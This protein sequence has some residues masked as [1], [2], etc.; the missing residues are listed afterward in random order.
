MTKSI[1]VLHIAAGDDWGGAES[2]ITGL[3]KNF[4]QFDN[5][6]CQIVTMNDGLLSERLAEAD[7]DCVILDEK[8]YSIRELWLQIRDVI[9]EY[10]PDIIHTH[11]YKQNILG[12]L[13]AIGFKDIKSVRTQH[14][15]WEISTKFFSIAFLY[16]TLD[17]LFAR[18]LQHRTIAVSH[19]LKETLSRHVNRRKIVII[20]NG[21]DTTLYNVGNEVQLSNAGD[22]FVIA[23][24]GRLVPV[25]RIDLFLNS[26]FIVIQQAKQSVRCKVYGDGP[27]KESATILAER[28][29][30]TDKVDFCGFLPELATH[31]AACDLLL[32]TSDHEGLPMVLLESL[33]MKIPVVAPAI[34]GIPEILDKEFGALVNSQDPENY[35]EAILNCMHRAP[36]L[37]T[38][39]RRASKLIEHSYSAKRQAGKYKDFY[40]GL[41]SRS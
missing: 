18:F 27:Q 2:Q 20:Q 1:R 19:A 21:L 41:I 37:S 3:L 40:L 17:L 4:G 12:T 39:M 23:F 38:S 9:R 25:K 16:R 6:D 34:G 7:V 26:A 10:Q 15:D 36:Q 28:L 31:L 5:V 14:G 32:M 35:A 11:G 22:D 29:G 33:Y 24:V 13:A 8:S 30:I